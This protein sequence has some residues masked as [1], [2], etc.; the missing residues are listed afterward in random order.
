MKNIIHAYGVTASPLQLSAVLH[1][2]KVSHV[3]V[4]DSLRSDSIVHDL[5]EKQPAWP[6]VVP[7][8]KAFK[9][10]HLALR[11]QIVYLCAA[12]PEL[13]RTNL[14]IIKDYKINIGASLKHAVVNEFAAD[15]EFSY[16]DPSAESFVHEIS[17]PSFL[18]HVQALLYKINPYDLR[19]KAQHSIIAY[20]GGLQSK[21]SMREVL[22]TSYKLEPLLKMMA[23]PEAAVL[24]NAILAYRVSKDEKSVAKEYGV[25]TFDIMYL[26]KSSSPK[27]VKS[28]KV[29]KEK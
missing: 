16:N 23:E 18:N 29:G 26:F 9:R 20:L 5:A 21:K 10:H 4:D 2:L 14:R 1:Q 28:E 15:W 3:V 8:I 11:R 17:K 25:E 6:V 13:K 7:S 19:K 24:R 22:L 27:P 12:E